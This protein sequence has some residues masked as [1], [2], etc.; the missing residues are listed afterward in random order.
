MENAEI[1]CAA[2]QRAG[3]HKHWGFG[4]RQGGARQGETASGQWGPWI[5]CPGRDA[6]PQAQGIAARPRTR[7]LPLEWSCSGRIDKSD[8]MSRGCRL[9]PAGSPGCGLLAAGNPML[10]PFEPRPCH[11]GSL[12]EADPLLVA[13]LGVH[14][15]RLN[16]AGSDHLVFPER[17]LHRPALPGVNYLGGSRQLR[18]RVPPSL[19]LPWQGDATPKTEPPAGL[20]VADTSAR[21]CSGAREP[22]DPTVRRQRGA[23]TGT[24]RQC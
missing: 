9:V 21:T 7:P 3:S 23:H 6:H 11:S 4:D 12:G 20:V 14:G 1:R 5:L 16:L 8:Q 17:G 24:W 2:T 13:G 15:Y 22:A 19:P 10:I 18:R